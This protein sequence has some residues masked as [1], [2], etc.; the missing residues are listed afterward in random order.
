M[1]GSCPHHC[2]L[3]AFSCALASRAARTK[4]ASVE[5]ST[6]C[7]MNSCYVRG[8]RWLAFLLY[9]RVDAGKK[10]T[11]YPQKI[12]S[13]RPLLRVDLERKVQKV[14]EDG[15]HLLLVLDLWRA[16]RSD[17]PQGAQR[18]LGQVGWLALNHLDG[19]DAQ[20]PNVHFAAVLLPRNHLRRHPIR[21]ADHCCTLVLR[22]VDGRTEPKV[23]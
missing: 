2:P 10:T 22:L 11:T 14:A 23:G 8:V 4:G 5:R 9:K 20:R 13:A 16:V 12:M 19:H 1:E 17:Q 6:H 18:R 3:R 21:R 7:F 15:R